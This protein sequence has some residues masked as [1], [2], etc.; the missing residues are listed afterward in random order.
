MDFKRLRILR[1]LADRG[2]VGATAE[3][4]NVTPSAVSQQL[5]TLQEEL[6]V[7]LVEKSGR[8]V[9]L[10]EA[11]LAMA[12]AAAEVATA[13]AK[14][15]ATVDTYR[16]RLADAGQGGFLSQRRRDVPAGAAA[17]GQGH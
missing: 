5:K 12:G 3:A 7:V 11:G 8:G 15:E 4:M 13:M 1:E 17:P 6:G 9:R 16:L 2:T 14:A 10:T